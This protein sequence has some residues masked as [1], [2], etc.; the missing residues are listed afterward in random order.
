M[1]TQI[2]K[3]ITPSTEEAKKASSSNLDEI[4]TANNCIGIFDG[5]PRYIKYDLNA[6]AEME[7][8]YG[9]M[10]TAQE[11][12]TKGSMTD[13]RRMLWVGVIHDEANLDEI[14][15]E[16]ISY[17]LSAYQVG[18]WLT[19]DNMKSVMKSLS[20]AISGSMPADDVKESTE[21][22]NESMQ[23]VHVKIDEDDPDPNA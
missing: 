19:P 11:K 21:T 8:L 14:T 7:R 5:K 4:R 18:K 12:L 17:N 20:D 13:I 23:A 10:E 9:D 2:I 3:T 16:P 6:F 15:G 1:G 22:I